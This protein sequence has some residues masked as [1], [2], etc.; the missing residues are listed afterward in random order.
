M[1]DAVWDYCSWVRLSEQRLR[2]CSARS[3]RLHESATLD[4]VIVIDSS[5]DAVSRSLPHWKISN[6]IPFGVGFTQGLLPYWLPVNIWWTEPWVIAQT[7]RC[8]HFSHRL[9]AVDIPVS[10]SHFATGIHCALLS[11]PTFWWWQEHNYY[12]AYTDARPVGIS[13]APHLL[14]DTIIMWPILK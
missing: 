9:I 7:Y 11:R 1:L 8:W 12:V 14:R 5:L 13:T 6:L 2:A 4:N 3:W 10:A